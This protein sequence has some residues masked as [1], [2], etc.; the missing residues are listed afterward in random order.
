MRRARGVSPSLGGPAD[1]PPRKAS[2]AEGDSEEIEVGVGRMRR[3]WTGARPPFWDTFT[4]LNLKFYKIFEFDDGW[5]T[6]EI[7]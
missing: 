1:E 2:A 7:T 5:T 4:I 3:G 6:L